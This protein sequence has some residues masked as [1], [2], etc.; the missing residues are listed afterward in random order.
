MQEMNDTEFL[1]MVGQLY[2]Y[3]LSKRMTT[4]TY[5]TCRST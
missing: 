3:A 4:I 2:E 5:S 1:R